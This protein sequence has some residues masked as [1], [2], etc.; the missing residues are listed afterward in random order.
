MKNLIKACWV[1]IIICFI[2]KIFGGNYFEIICTNEKFIDFCNLVDGSFVGYLIL[3]LF[4]MFG[5]NIMYL[6]VLKQKW[7]KGKQNWILLFLTLY[8]LFKYFVKIDAILFVTDTLIAFVPLLLYRNKIT[9]K[10]NI[11]G[12]ILFF[13]FQVLSL[14]VRNIGFKMIDDNLV[15][16]IIM[17]IDYYLMLFL[18]YLYSIKERRQ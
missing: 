1:S 2:I 12:A 7:Y 13:L 14:I 15:I 9:L 11:L 6:A 5:L 3:Y 17:S 18:Y 8:W 10:R 4:Y 16:F